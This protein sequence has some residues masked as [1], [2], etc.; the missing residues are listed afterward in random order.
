[1]LIYF[2]DDID[3]YAAAIAFRRYAADVRYLPPRFP[4]ADVC[5]CYAT[6]HTALLDSAATDA[7]SVTR[8]RAA[9]RLRRALALMLSIR[10]FRLPCH[11][12]AAADAAALRLIHA[13]LA[14]AADAAFSPMLP[15]EREC[16][17][18]RVAR[19]YFFCC[20]DTPP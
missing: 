12:A 17:T 9:M 18:A 3:A 11:G 2:A 5:C 7:V 16:V 4:F 15:L 10:Y 19:Y 14:A 20:D 1:M 13:M 8:C 6:R